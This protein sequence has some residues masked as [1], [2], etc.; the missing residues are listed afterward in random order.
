[1]VN[2]DLGFWKSLALYCS[3]GIGGLAFLM[4]EKALIQGRA[5][6]SVCG[7]S[8]CVYGCLGYEFYQIVT[9]ITRF[10]KTAK[11]TEVQLSVLI[12]SL[13]STIVQCTMVDGG[14]VGHFAHLGGFITGF[15]FAHYW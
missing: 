10:K 1:M 3:S 7:S 15:L 13:I 5:Y 11:N 14:S 9:R 12:Y 4:A 6:Y 8:A 2:L